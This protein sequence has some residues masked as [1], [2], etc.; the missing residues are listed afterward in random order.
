MISKQDFLDRV[1]TQI[2][3]ILSSC[4]WKEKLVEIL[5]FEYLFATLPI[6]SVVF[7]WV[8]CLIFSSILSIDFMFVKLLSV[9]SSIFLSVFLFFLSLY[10]SDKIS[11]KIDIQVEPTVFSALNLTPLPKTSQDDK[12]I[13]NLS[14]YG[15]LP[16]FN[17][18]SIEQSF[19]L[20]KTYCNLSASFL[21][22]AYTDPEHI[23]STVFTGWLV[24]SKK[25]FWTNSS[26]LI[27]DK[28]HEY[29]L[30]QEKV[31][32]NYPKKSL[33]H[34]QRW[35][36]ID[37][38]DSQLNNEYTIYGINIHDAKQIF[39]PKLIEG[40]KKIKS[41]YST[42]NI[43]INKNGIFIALEKQDGFIPLLDFDME[44]ESY[45]KFYDTFQNLVELDSVLSDFDLRL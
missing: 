16:I 43:L 34:G 20:K 6:A 29:N 45:E 24:S 19:S 3:P 38:N 37:C 4:K 21:E 41:I 7:Y 30:S 33:E 1:Q 13:N 12:L 35:E 18:Y 17:A 2:F 25:I 23:E 9:F 36:L 5:S 28:K 8:F 11:R 32:Q 26:L 40:I 44:L 27:L 31:T 14:D 15:F 10:L 39:S 22:L 42:S